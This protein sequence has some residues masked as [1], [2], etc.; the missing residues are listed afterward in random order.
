MDILKNTETVAESVELTEEELEKIA[1][2]KLVEI[3]EAFA[4]QGYTQ[5]EIFDKFREIINSAS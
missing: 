1:T 4:Q 2:K 3:F 5:E